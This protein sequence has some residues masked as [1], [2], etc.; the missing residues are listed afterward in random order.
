MQRGCWNW[1]ARRGQPT[2]W[3]PCRPVAEPAK[4][5]VVSGALRRWP[6]LGEDVRSAPVGPVRR[7]HRPG[8]PD[9]RSLGHTPPWRCPRAGTS[10]PRCRSPASTQGTYSIGDRRAWPHSTAA[11][12]GFETRA[13]PKVHFGV[14][15]GIQGGCDRVGGGS[16]RGARRSVRHAGEGVELARERALHRA[17]RIPGSWHSPT[18]CLEVPRAPIHASV[19]YV[20]RK[21]ELGILRRR[22]HTETLRLDSSVH[23]LNGQDFR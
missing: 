12:T 16:I 2:L 18:A 7:T 5:A 14:E 6:V 23:Q 3:Q 10:W 11:R 20:H 17:G 9:R 19:I 1:G 4:S 8:E 22:W 15:Q 21:T 13:N